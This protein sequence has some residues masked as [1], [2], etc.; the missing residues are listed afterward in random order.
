VDSVLDERERMLLRELAVSHWQ[1]KCAKFEARKAAALKK[2]AEYEK[3]AA[4][5]K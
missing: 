1:G 5:S 2:K 4:G 3:G